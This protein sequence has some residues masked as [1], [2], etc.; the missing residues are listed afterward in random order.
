MM[1]RRGP[2]RQLDETESPR[3]PRRQG[4]R[5]PDGPPDLRVAKRR[6]QRAAWRALVAVLRRVVGWGR[7]DPTRRPAGPRLEIRFLIMHAY[8]MGGTIRTVLNIAGAL[9]EHH[10]VE[11]TTIVRR[12]DVPFFPF[13]EGVRV[14]TLDDRRPDHASP[15]LARLLRRVPGLLLYRGDY[16]FRSASLWA[17]VQLVRWLRARGPGVLIGTRPGLNVIAAAIAPADV[18]TI[19]QEHLNL[20]TYRPGL[21]AQIRRAYRGLDALAVLTEGDLRDYRKALDGAR[22]RIVQIPNAVTPL[23]GDR[24][25]LSNRVV[26][27]AGR[28][29]PQ[30]GFDLLI[31]AFALV[32]EEH[33]DWKLRIFGDGRERHRLQ[34]MI[35]QRGLQEHVFLMG[36]TDDM[37]R[38]LANASMFAL[39]SRFEGFG[40]VIVEAMSKGVPVVS[41][42]CRRGPAEIITD[43]VDG[44]LV[45]PRDVRGLADGLLRLMDDE[46]E[47]RR[48]GAAAILTAGRYDLPS[49]TARWLDLLRDLAPPAATATATARG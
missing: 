29:T 43:G 6:A 11:V 24:S 45:R 34:R 36:R 15:W 23:A 1:A 33:P 26:V 5:L 47:R 44:L 3:R 19:G 32:V 17:D 31:R 25:D 48:M 30:K 13:P 12:R 7:Q 10:D 14:T 8:G 49:I 42:R 18:V 40:L 9:A 46:E 37:G 22:T 35:R 4:R 21:V 41:F 20:R 16:A 2:R 27:A 38:E 28:L 39:S